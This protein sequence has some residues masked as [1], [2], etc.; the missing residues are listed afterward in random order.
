MAVFYSDVNVNTLYFLI[1][2]GW[3]TNKYPGEQ[4]PLIEILWEWKVFISI[5]TDL[6]SSYGFGNPLLIWKAFIFR[7]QIWRGKASNVWNFLWKNCAGINYTPQEKSCYNGL[8]QTYTK[9]LFQLHNNSSGV[10][11]AP[12]TLFTASLCIYRSNCMHS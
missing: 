9:T 8:S 3:H 6:C 1:M 4:S 5:H 11:A 7:M 2:R 10:Q 12:T